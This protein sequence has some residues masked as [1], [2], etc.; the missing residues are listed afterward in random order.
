V[1]GRRRV[2]LTTCGRSKNILAAFDSCKT[3]KIVAVALFGLGGELECRA[4]VGIQA[5]PLYM[6]RLQEWHGLV[7]HMPCARVE[8]V[9]FAQSQHGGNNDQNK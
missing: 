2:S 4:D 7:G 8:P 5:P 1:A 3:R 9:L 6:P